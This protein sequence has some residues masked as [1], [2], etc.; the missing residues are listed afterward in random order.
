[1]NQLR[2]QP[3]NPQVHRVIFLH[4]NH[5]YSREGFLR[6]NHLMDHD[7]IQ[8]Y[9][10]LEVLAISHFRSHPPNPA[11]NL[12]IS[13]VRTLLVN[14]FIGQRRHL[15]CNHLVNLLPVHLLL[16]HLPVQPIIQ[17]L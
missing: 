7:F 16:V 3:Y 2:F 8:Q 12:F 10:Q 5:P 15:V 9:N 11:T 6:D 1:M 4:L 13:L 14:I 17:I